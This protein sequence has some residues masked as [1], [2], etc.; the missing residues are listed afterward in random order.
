MH[1]DRHI[2]TLDPSFME[3]DLIELWFDGLFAKLNCTVNRVLILITFEMM[4]C[5]I[6]L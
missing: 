6:D 4:E 3:L 2:G 1:I 5:A